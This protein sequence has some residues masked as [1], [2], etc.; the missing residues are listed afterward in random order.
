MADLQKQ[1]NKFHDNIKLSDENELLI[2]KR[3]I[4]KDTADDDQLDYLFRLMNIEY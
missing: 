2:E 1:F 4:L 3:D